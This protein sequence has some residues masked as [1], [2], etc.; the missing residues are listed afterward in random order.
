MAGAG[1]SMR[2]AARPERRGT[3][4]PDGEEGGDA[5]AIQNTR[6]QPL[7]AVELPAPIA[8]PLRS[9]DPRLLWRPR[10]AARPSPAVHGI[11]PAAWLA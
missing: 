7:P 2:A 1:E 11:R 8:A 9:I 4:M 5:A 3:P 10:R 6:P